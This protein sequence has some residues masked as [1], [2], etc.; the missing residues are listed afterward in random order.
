MSDSVP[1]GSESRNWLGQPCPPKP[2]CLAVA[3]R[4][5]DL[6]R[7]PVITD[8]LHPLGESTAVEK[9][10]VHLWYD[11]D[12]LYLRAECRTAAMARVE[13][14]AASAPEYGRD[15]W[16][17]DALEVQLDPG[18]TRTRY[19][20]FILPPTGKGVTYLGYDNRLE[21]GCR[22]P[23]SF[24]VSF[25]SDAWI[26]AAGFPFAGLGGTPSAGA[27]WGLNLV[28]VNPSEPRRYVQWAPTLMS[29]CLH[30]A[31]FGRLE[32]VETGSDA[33]QCQRR[34]REV[35]EF[36]RWATAEKSEFL[37]HVHHL[38]DTD[39]LAALD[40][41]FPD[42]PAWAE[43]L[44]AR[45]G[46]RPLRWEALALDAQDI[47]TLDRENV[48]TI[49]ADICE[50]IAAGWGGG[51]PL[52]FRS[53]TLVDAYQL[54]GEQGYLDAFEEMVE[55]FDYWSAGDDVP[56]CPGPP[57]YIDQQVVNAS[58]MAYAYFIFAAENRLQPAT[59]D[60]VLKTVLRLARFAARN[61]GRGYHY[62]NHQIFESSA[63]AVLALLFPE[64]RESADWAA[65][66]SRS[67]AKHLD[68]EVL[69]DGGYAE[70]CGYHSVAM[71][72]AAHA[73]AAIRLNA[74]EARFP[75]FTADAIVAKLESM[76]EW[77]MWMSAPD[78]TMPAFGD[79]GAYSQLRLLRQGAYIF[80]RAD[81]AGIVAAAA[82]E[83]A[84][85]GV[86][87]ALPPET[88]ISLAASNFTV[89]RSAWEGQALYMALDHGGL[90]GQH[91]HIDNMGFVAYAY[92]APIALDSGIGTSYD[93]PAYRNWYREA[94][95]HNVV[96][97]DGREPEKASERVLWHSSP[98]ADLLIMRSRGY[99]H[100][101]GVTHE[102]V[103]FFVKD[104]LWLICDRL[105]AG[106]DGHR[107]EWLLHTPMDLQPAPGGLDGRHAET[108]VGLR[109]LTACADE[110]EPPVI[111]RR[112]CAY[113]LAQDAARRQA[114]QEDVHSVWPGS[115]VADLPFIALPKKSSLGGS[116]SFATVLLPYRHDPPAAVLKTVRPQRAGK[117]CDRREAEAFELTVGERLF[118]L[119]VSDGPGEYPV[120]EVEFHGR[121]G[122]AC[123]ESGGLAWV[124]T[125]G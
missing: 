15:S 7:L 6:D 16:G 90:G 42:L 4:D 19:W 120:G 34:Q 46:P 39:V 63:L 86:L 117:P 31:Q 22:P 57:L 60:R 96:L 23:F 48:M 61:I 103:V 85:P 33:E 116:T 98:R 5:G 18:L 105:T 21:Q 72:F 67:L 87:P 8:F 80:Q 28:R 2:D 70:R 102:R 83:L 30:P 94:R 1:D 35:A 107:Y 68:R 77:V 89:M 32:F 113:P 101:C 52:L 106:D 44:A 74:A 54:T 69:P 88:S 17:Q 37:G 76:Y 26:V 11:D 49:A 82:P 79:Y 14:I 109:L 51:S 93:D 125:A 104:L 97:V 108:S 27:A 25:T 3:C 81:V 66:A 43:H 41:S 58:A 40:P 56:A 9:T 92:S 95:A 118:F 84:P 99:E 38:A 91:S 75:E 73:L 45:T 59:H 71:M 50:Q 115:S 55:Q 123:F 111:D 13:E 20:S 112:L 24:S 110:L 114:R 124:E 62:G 64:F 122:L 65:T 121:I 12:R 100:D 10:L 29:D 36:A 119:I 78:G 47:R 53:E